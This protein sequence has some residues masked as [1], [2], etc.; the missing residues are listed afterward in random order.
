MTKWEYHVEPECGLI[1]EKELDKLGAQGWELIEVSPHGTCLIFKRP[2]MDC[3]IARNAPERFM[4]QS[5]ADRAAL[6]WLEQLAT[7]AA[8]PYRQIESK[9]LEQ[10]E[11]GRVTMFW[12]NNQLAAAT[13]VVRDSANFSVLIKWETT[14]EIDYDSIP[15][16]WRRV[17]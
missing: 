16:E 15:D 14:L 5:D 1:V 13:I 2:K 6:A 10:S 17:T 12:H 9:N 4:D 3:V 7:T 8:G 11:G